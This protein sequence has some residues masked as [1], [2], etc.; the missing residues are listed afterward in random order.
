MDFLDQQFAS[1]NRAQYAGFLGLENLFN[2]I[3]KKPK[4]SAYQT[5]L[6]EKFPFSDNCGDQQELVYELSL[7]ANR[8]WQQKSV[9]KN[10]AELA[11]LEQQSIILADYRSKA[12]KYMDEVSCPVAPFVITQQ[13]IIPAGSVPVL[14]SIPVNNTSST[15]IYPVPPAQPVKTQLIKGVDN[16]ILGLAAAGVVALA[17]FKVIKF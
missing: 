8:L 17:I 10:Q 15:V 12:N 9:I 14:N 3:T 6:A 16:K 4:I 11:E 5:Y 13:T 2:K 7:E 1:V